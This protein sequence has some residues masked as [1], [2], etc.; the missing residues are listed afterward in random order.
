VVFE[1]NAES[2]KTLIPRRG[3]DEVSFVEGFSSF[4]FEWGVCF[5]EIEV[6]RGGIATILDPSRKS[7]RLW[8]AGPP[9]ESRGV[10]G[11]GDV[12]ETSSLRPMVPTPVIFS[13][14]ADIVLGIWA[15][16]T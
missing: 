15:R 13:A 2:L 1:E 14:P 10:H 4:V 9:T 11:D 12:D 16:R 8:A 5:G 6:K 7:E 3:G